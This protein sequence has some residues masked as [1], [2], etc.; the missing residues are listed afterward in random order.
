MAH[1]ELDAKAGLR[2]RKPLLR[3]AGALEANLVPGQLQMAATIEDEVAPFLGINSQAKS[4]ENT[5]SWA[6]SPHRELR[7][8]GAGSKST[9][10]SNGRINELTNIC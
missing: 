8:C 1:H 3:L 2:S 5:I 4:N 9:S 10:A 7:K 6:K